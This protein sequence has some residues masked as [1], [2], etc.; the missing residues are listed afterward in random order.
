MEQ[1]RGIPTCRQSGH[2]ESGCERGRG[3][4]GAH[5]EGRRYGRARTGARLFNKMS[6]F[7]CA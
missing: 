2:W 3:R 1:T 7:T 6:I 4:L 5:R